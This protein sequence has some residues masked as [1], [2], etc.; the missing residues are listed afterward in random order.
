MYER[1]ASAIGGSLFDDEETDSYSAVD[2]A[3]GNGHLDV[4]EFLHN[5]DSAAYKRRKQDGDTKLVGFCDANCS[6][7]AMDGAASNGHLNAVKWLHAHRD[8]G[9]TTDA[10]DSEAAN[11]HLKVVQWLHRNR[12]EG[13]T[14]RRW[15]PLPK[16]GI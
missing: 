15:I 9:C 1:L 3:A 10:M 4:L 2:A 6:E 11:G 12:S 5:A 7:D 13:C 14:K 8:E 16:T